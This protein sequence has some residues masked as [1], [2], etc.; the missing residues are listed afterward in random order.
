MPR[1][2][3]DEPFDASQ[4]CMG[5]CVRRTFLTGGNPVSGTDDSFQRE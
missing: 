1:P 4:V 2:K 5:Q 3:R